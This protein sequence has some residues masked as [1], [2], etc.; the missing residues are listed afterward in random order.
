MMRVLHVTSGNLFGGIE[1][2]LT[3]LA[4]E[5]RLCPEMEPH[6]ALCF[7]GKLS[8]AL[9]GRGVPVHFLGN[10]R[11]S[12]PWTV[13]SARRRLRELLARES[14]DAVACHG[15]WPHAVFA[16]EVRAARRPLVFWAHNAPGGRHWL[17]RWARRTPP[18]LVVANSRWTASAV[19]KLFPGLRCEVA[20]VPVSEPAATDRGAARRRLRA[21]LGAPADAVVVVQA[22]RLEPWKGH[23]LLLEA[24]AGLGD[25]PSWICWVAGGPQRPAE[26]QY[27][28]QL[29]QDAARRG[30]AGRVRFLGQR[31]DVPELLAA[32]DVHCQPNTEPEPFGIAFVE[33]LYA[34]LPVVTTAIGGAL[35]IVDESCGVLTPPGDAAAL[36]AS[37]RRLLTDEVTRR[38][39]G[40]AGRERARAL[41]DPPVRLAKIAGL[42]A[43]VV[44]GRERLERPRIAAGA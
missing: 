36:A 5:R 32:A 19:P 4:R 43:A 2:F 15:C 41:C 17:E 23:A 28:E 8:E 29:R 9:D 30:I 24:L 35:E 6:F 44:N 22:S 39:L 14:F 13:W 25:A 11:V 3:T 37:L 40:D 26:A 1:S 38:R 20:Y 27:L 12:R 10:V 34:G 21:A 33:A 16:P 7:V 42:F 31:S 18:D